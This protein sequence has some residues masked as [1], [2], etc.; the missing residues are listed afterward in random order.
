[1]DIQF[2]MPVSVVMQENCVEENGAAV[3]ACGGRAVVVADAHGAESGALRDVTAV[4]RKENITGSI[5]TVDRY[6]TSAE[7]SDFA[8]KN[9]RFGAELVISAGGEFAVNAGKALSMLLAQDGRA[10]EFAPGA[11]SSLSIPHIVVPTTAR[12]GNEVTPLL[13]FRGD[14]RELC[15]FSDPAL[16]ARLALLDYRYT[17][18][19]PWE[20]AV[21]GAFSTIACAIEAVLSAKSSRFIR[22]IAW[23]SLSNTSAVLLALEEDLVDVGSRRMMMYD[24]VLAGIAIGQTQASGLRGI[25]R[26][27]TRDRGMPQGKAEGLLLVPYLRFIW[28]QKPH[29]IDMILHSMGFQNL[30]DFSKKA[31]LLLSNKEVF[32][33]AEIERW[34]VE[35]AALPDVANCVAVL[36][37]RDIAQILRMI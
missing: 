21:H 17:A 20:A 12:A 35:A 34:A 15:L 5:V 27:L 6:M 33:A 29:L 28:R 26:L 13:T 3:S 37:E 19:I 22:A 1:M 36:S 30:D 10:A 2:K 8:R 7:L 18:A 31:A 25:S 9:R 14:S 11:L 4:L 24:S 16:F 32:S 23:E